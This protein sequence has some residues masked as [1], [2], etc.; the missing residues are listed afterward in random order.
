MFLFGICGLYYTEHVQTRQLRITS[1]TW[2]QISSE[3]YTALCSSYI[4]K[5]GKEI[6]I[7]S[8]YAFSGHKSVVDN[9]NQTTSLYKLNLVGI[10]FQLITKRLKS[11]YLNQDTYCQLVSL[12]YCRLFFSFELSQCNFQT[13]T[14]LLVT[15]LKITLC[16][17]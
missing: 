4:L 2:N 11:E 8:W 5:K 3:N 10:E 1:I 9:F 15:E 16:F 12:E 13:Q 17:Y 7:V 6:E 14:T